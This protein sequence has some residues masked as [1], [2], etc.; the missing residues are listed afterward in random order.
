[1]LRREAIGY[2]YSVSQVRRPEPLTKDPGVARL[3]HS[4][5]DEPVSRCVA[6]VVRPAV[7]VVDDPLPCVPFLP[8]NVPFDIGDVWCALPFPRTGMTRIELRQAP[9]PPLL[10]FLLLPRSL[11]SFEPLPDRRAHDP[12]PGQLPL[13]RLLRVQVPQEPPRDSLARPQR[14]DE[15]DGRDDRVGGERYDEV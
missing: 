8:P 1:V 4:D 3:A 12:F 7:D 9:Q 5:G 2:S 10:P 11:L 15:R 6:D 13:A 14:H